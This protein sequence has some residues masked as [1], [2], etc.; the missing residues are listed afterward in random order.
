MNKKRTSIIL[1]VIGLITLI[2][3]VVFLIVRLTA[4]PSVADG[5]YLVSVGEWKIK[6]GK[7]LQSKCSGDT[8]CINENGESTMI[9]DGDNVIW[10]FTE[11]GKGTLTTNNHIND[12]DFTWTIED[13]RLRIDTEWLYTLSNEFDYTLD[14]NENILT[15]TSGNE[16]TVF[17]PLVT[18]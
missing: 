6:G 8:K 2:A 14:Q 7:C 10:N 17:V 11:I 4:G 5:N 1:L 18:E 12:Y 15:L 3:G 9:C 13:G 16:D